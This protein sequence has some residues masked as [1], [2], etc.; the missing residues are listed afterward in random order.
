LPTNCPGCC[1]NNTCF[2]GDT[3]TECGRNGASCQSCLFTQTCGA[4]AC[5]DPKPTCQGCRPDQCCKGGTCVAGTSN[6]QCGKSGADCLDCTSQGSDFVC[7]TGSCI[8][9]TGYSICI[10]SL[11]VNCDPEDG[12]GQCSE[13]EE[14]PL[15]FKIDVKIGSTTKS[16]TAI[17]T[18]IDSIDFAK[19]DYNQCIHQNL[20]EAA[21]TAG[22]IEVTVW[23]TDPSSPD[24]K[25]DE[26]SISWKVDDL[27][28]GST[29]KLCGYDSTVN[30]EFK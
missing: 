1:K 16:T 25:V 23:E 3:I 15:S 21:I 4:G 17:T 12:N 9:K 13:D 10:K 5:L 19:V 11:R 20:S 26:C 27:K 24:D 8:Q 6:D 2:A 29:S 7:Q 22:V 18:T 30:V 14:A 28:R